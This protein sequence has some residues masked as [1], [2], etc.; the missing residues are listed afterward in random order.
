MVKYC[1][2]TASLKLCIPV[3][4]FPNSAELRY[5]YLKWRTVSQ[6]LSVCIQRTFGEK[7]KSF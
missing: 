7:E 6:I 5:F 3:V 4:T 1:T 2:W